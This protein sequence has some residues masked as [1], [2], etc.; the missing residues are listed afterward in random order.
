VAT[1]IISKR[2][3]S[4]GLESQTVSETVAVVNEKIKEAEKAKARFIEVTDESGK[5]V[6][7]ECARIASFKEQ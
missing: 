1:L 4:S 3:N 2:V 7:V 6:S 5:A